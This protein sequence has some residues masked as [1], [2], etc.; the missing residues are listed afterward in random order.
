MKTSTII[1]IFAEKVPEA[2]AWSRGEFY[3]P[4]G[5]DSEADIKKILFCV[6]PT[7]A[8]IKY[9]KKNQ[10]DLLISHHPFR[11]S[12]PQIIL[13]TALDCCEG[14]LNDIWRDVVGVRD[15]KHFDGTLGWH[16]AIEPI[17]FT[18]L[19]QKCEDFM[20]GKVRGQLYHKIETIRSV[21]ICTGLGGLVTTQAR[22]TGA[23][24]Y[25][26]G[27]LC[28]PAHSVGLPAVIETGHTLS[29]RCGV[30]VIRRLL[31]DMRV[32]TAPLKIDVF[33]SEYYRN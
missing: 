21:V 2:I 11:V 3:G 18:A 12:V 20:G 19:V 28:S 33:G 31:P 1:N 4:N 24:L 32:D 10:Y 23:D 26:T 25:L 15:A 17:S 30:D 29:E 13:H 22:N 14:G 7:E 9:F 5:V 16:G 8:V 6:T 27:E